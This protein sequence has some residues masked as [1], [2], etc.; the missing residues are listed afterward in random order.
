MAALL[1]VF[2]FKDRLFKA[3]S[4]PGGSDTALLMMVGSACLLLIGLIV[5]SLLKYRQRQMMARAGFGSASGTGSPEKVSRT[6]ANSASADAAFGAGVPSATPSPAEWRS[7]CYYSTPEQMRNCFPGPTAQI[8]ICR[9]ELHLDGQ[10]LTFTAP[11]RPKVV[12]GLKTIQ[13]LTFGRFQMETRPWFR[14]TG[15]LTYLV[16]TYGEGGLSRTLHLAPVGPGLAAAGTNDSYISRWYE[17]IHQ[18]IIACTGQ[19]PSTALPDGIC[20]SAERAWARKGFPLFLAGGCLLGLAVGLWRSGDHSANPLAVVALV[21]G[22]LLFGT[23][24][25][26]GIGFTR[27][28]RALKRGDWDAVTVDVPPGEPLMTDQTARRD[29]A[30]AMPSPGLSPRNHGSA[31]RTP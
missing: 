11:C 7:A 13:D 14:K 20:I 15:K 8:F 3:D 12:I 27:A 26:F 18:G 29:P 4:V 23:G 16:V 2:G 21:G 10:N 19:A 6:Q 25:V 9:G 5:M 22:I 31:S 28:N 24:L 17:R 30:V 1:L